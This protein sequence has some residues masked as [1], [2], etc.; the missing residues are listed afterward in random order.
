[1]RVRENKCMCIL[2][3]CVSHTCVCDFQYFSDILS[4]TVYA[5]ALCKASR[6][7]GRLR[8]RALRNFQEEKKK[9]RA[10]YSTLRLVYAG[11]DHFLFSFSIFFLFLSVFLVQFFSLFPCLFLLQPCNEIHPFVSHCEK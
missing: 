10:P 2:Y 4:D 3:V 8:L 7:K 1:M 5:V 9:H 11:S 6:R